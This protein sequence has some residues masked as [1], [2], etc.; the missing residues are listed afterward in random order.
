MFSVLNAQ[1]DLVR[2]VRIVG[3]IAVDGARLIPSFYS[4]PTSMW[5]LGTG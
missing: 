4:W 3:L 2:P 1:A 5:P